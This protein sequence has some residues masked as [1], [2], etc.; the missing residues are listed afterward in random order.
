MDGWARP[1]SATDVRD[2]A[3]VVNPA[4]AEAVRTIFES[5]RDLGSVRELRAELDR[6]GL[7]SKRRINRHG[8]ASGGARFSRGALYAI[9]R[10]RLYLG[11]IAHRGEVHP[12]KHEA[13]LDRDL[14]DEVQR[15]LAGNG[16]RPITGTRRPACDDRLLTG[17]LF[18]SHGR[19]M[20][21]TH[22]QR[23]M[24]SGGA[25]VKK[26]YWYYVSQLSGP[27]DGHPV[28]RLPA[29]QIERLVIDTLMARL[30]DASAV[31]D[32]RACAGDMR[33]AMP[34]R[35]WSG[36]GTSPRGS[37]RARGT[38]RASVDACPS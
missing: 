25:T 38:D 24:R 15:I 30:G 4:E 7:R 1:R 37:V 21:P 13:I 32:L 11:E 28:A 26:R 31:L 27:D 35:P 22:A 6:L 36:R 20:R 9:L 16:G 10:N 3:L 2:K 14:W 12:G 18:D 19:P 17:F 33:R 23:T 8:R 5:Y 34:A 29:E